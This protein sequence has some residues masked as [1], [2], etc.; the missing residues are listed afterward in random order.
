[1][2]TP[3]AGKGIVTAPTGAEL[4]PVSPDGKIQL[5][6]FGLVPIV[7]SPEG[8]LNGTRNPDLK[9]IDVTTAAVYV[10]QGVDGT[11]T[12][13]IRG[14]LPVIA[15]IA[16]EAFLDVGTGTSEIRFFAVTAGAAGND[17]SV[18][19]LNP[20]TPSHALTVTVVGDKLSIT[21]ATNGGSTIISTSDDVINAVEAEPLAARWDGDSHG[22][23]VVAPLAATNLAGGADTTTVFAVADDGTVTIANATQANQQAI[24]FVDRYGNVLGFVQFIDAIGKQG[25]TLAFQS[26]RSSLTFNGNAGVQIAPYDTTNVAD[27]LSIDDVDANSGSGFDKDQYFWT[28][29]HTAPDD[30]QLAPDV[31]EAMFYIDRTPG[32]EALKV[33]I[34]NDN[35]DVVILTLTA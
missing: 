10:F 6:T 23:G 21:L 28:N 35:N 17:L 27:I 16:Q 9:A 32:S 31:R 22:A 26:P 29:K 30:G 15:D 3:I 34:L 8:V 12:G 5:A 1:M 20:G 11:N 4:F 2:G 25:L 14:V 19:M 7:G 13:W 24:Q 33:K 18:E